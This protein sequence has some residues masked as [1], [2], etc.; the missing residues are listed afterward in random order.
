MCCGNP[1]PSPPVPGAPEPDAP[2]EPADTTV[3]RVAYFNG[4]TEDVTGL[5]A[6]RQRVINPASRAE[7]TDR[8]GLL[9]ATYA[10][11]R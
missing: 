7:G 8:D 6:V 10:P 5:D 9:G 11:V 4:T 1:E 2:S 3:Y